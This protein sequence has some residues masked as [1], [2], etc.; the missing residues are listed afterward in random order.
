MLKHLRLISIVLAILFVGQLGHL[1][2]AVSKRFLLNSGH[3]AFDLTIAVFIIINSFPIYRQAIQVLEVGQVAHDQ[4]DLVLSLQVD[5]E[6]AK[7]GQRS[8]A[9]NALLEVIE[10]DVLQVKV[11]DGFQ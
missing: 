8:D 5:V 11:C 4:V 1:T 2:V 9:L 7:V 10:G 3:L 6:A